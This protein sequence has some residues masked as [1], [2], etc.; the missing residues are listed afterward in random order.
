MFETESPNREE[1][2]VNLK[3]ILAGKRSDV[4]LQPNDILFVP[5]NIPKS[6]TL[7]AVEAAIQIGTGVVVWRR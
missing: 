5:D 1:I 4:P 2:S 3:E 7:R 6:A